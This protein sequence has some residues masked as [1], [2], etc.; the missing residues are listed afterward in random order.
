MSLISISELGNID[1]QLP[2]STPA[3]M[4]YDAQVWRVRVPETG[5]RTERDLNIL[6]AAEREQTLR[7][8]QQED[9][10]RYLVA[11][12]AL[13]RLLSSHTGIGAHQLT[14]TK[15]EF[16]KPALAPHHNAVNM[17]FNLSHS[18]QYVI[19]GLSR[20]PVGVDIEVVKSDFD[21]RNLLPHY[22][23][24]A[25][26]QSIINAVSQTDEFF[27]AWTRKEALGKGLGIGI[28]ENMQ[29]LPSLVGIDKSNELLFINGWKI[30]TFGTGDGHV[31][32]AAVS[33]EIKEIKFLDFIQAPSLSI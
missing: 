2:E 15:N 14:F 31:V 33:S 24:T 32:S 1:W 18:G 27:R 10:Q 5:V 21:F 22:F 6:N 26:A 8:V 9:A 17:H 3:L 30:Q 28:T 16:G 20:F 11:H 25:E 4:Q 29:K 12:S 23:T 7:F 19:I 13:R